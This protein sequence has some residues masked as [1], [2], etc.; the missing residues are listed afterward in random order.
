MPDDVS[1][2]RGCLLGGA[3][4]DALGAPVEFMKLDAIRAKFG[5]EGI[6]D[7]SPAYGKLGAVTDDTQMTL[8]TAEGLIRAYVRQALKGISHPAG[9]VHN[10]YLR[11]LST[12][13]VKV[14]LSV[15]EFQ[16][17]APPDGWLVAEK[18]LWSRRGPGQT[19][20]SA[21]S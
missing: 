16:K 2:I 19:C 20:L 21:L 8:F 9:V 5:A 17:T 13:R 11:W 3:L 1:R 6:Q 12:Q 7:L 4:G 14:V 18:E 10:A 15:E